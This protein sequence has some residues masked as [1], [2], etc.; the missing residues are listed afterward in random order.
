MIPQQGQRSGSTSRK[1]IC[2]DI[3]RDY[4]DRSPDPLVHSRTLTHFQRDLRGIQNIE[5]VRKNSRI[6]LAIIASFDQCP[7]LG[8]DD[9]NR[10]G[11]VAFGARA[12]SAGM[13]AS[14]SADAGAA[15][16]VPSSSP[17]LLEPDPNAHSLK[18]SALASSNRSFTSACSAAS[19]GRGRRLDPPDECRGACHLE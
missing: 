11:H 18:S 9:I 14:S 17:R 7:A 6:E 8:L 16:T 2:M 1:R 10:A 5:R 19:R 15:G 13:P 3:A 12:Y 4:P